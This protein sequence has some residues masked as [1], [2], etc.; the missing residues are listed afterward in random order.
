MGVCLVVLGLSLTAVDSLSSGEHVFAG[1]CLIVVGSSFHGLTYVLCEKIMT[2]LPAMSSSP[3][4][5]R[6]E[7]S[8]ALLQHE[9]HVQTTATTT[10]ISLQPLSKKQFIRREE[11]NHISVRANCAIQG[12]VAT[13]ALL[14]WQ[15]YYTLPPFDALI[16]TPLADARASIL[17]AVLI[18]S[19]VVLSNVLH[20]V[21]SF[22]H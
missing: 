1:A 18:L 20:S 16:I 10:T 21:D 3:L 8:T 19:G 14:L 11:P 7:S 4:Q 15:I 13:V 12:I 17:N 22:K 6:S 9:H 5:C 2:P